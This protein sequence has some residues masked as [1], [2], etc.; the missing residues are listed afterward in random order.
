MSLAV[1]AASLVSAPHVTSASSQCFIYARSG[2]WPVVGMTTAKNPRLHV[3]IL[4]AT[5]AG[6]VM[7]QSS[8]DSMN[9]IPPELSS[10]GE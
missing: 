6:A 5:C 9:D 3:Q 2:G 10:D 8:S 1:A 7:A 4:H